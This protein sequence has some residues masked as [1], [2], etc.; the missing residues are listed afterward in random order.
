MPKNST[1]RNTR[2]CPY[3]V[4]TKATSAGTSETTTSRPTP[5]IPSLSA[6]ALCAPTDTTTT[7]PRSQLPL[8]G[9]PQFQRK[10]PSATIKPTATDSTPPIQTNQTVGTTTSKGQHTFAYNLTATTPKQG[11]KPILQSSTNPNHCGTC[12]QHTP[13]H[14]HQSQPHST[15]SLHISAPSADQTPSIKTLFTHPS[16]PARP[17]NPSTLPKLPL[18]APKPFPL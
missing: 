4:S 15:P 5:R 7:I 11:S 1:A 17:L 16:L 12:D 8:K 2:F 9:L 18:T 6:E 3:P 13:L 14:R 10:D